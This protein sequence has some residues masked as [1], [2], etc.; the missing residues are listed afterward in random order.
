[1]ALLNGATNAGSPNRVRFGVAFGVAGSKPVLMMASAVGEVQRPRLDAHRY[2]RL[3][4]ADVGTVHAVRRADDLDVDPERLEV[5]L[6]DLGHVDEAWCV[7]LRP[8]HHGDRGLHAGFGHQLL[9]LGQVRGV[10]VEVELL[11]VELAGRDDVVGYGAGQRTAPL[12]QD[13]GAV[14]RV[15]DGLAHVHVVERRDLVVQEDV[16]DRRPGRG[17]H[18]ARPAPGCGE[19]F[20][21]SAVARLEVWKSSWPAWIS[22]TAWVDCTPIEK[23]ILATWPRTPSDWS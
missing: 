22:S 15:V 17:V 8:Q 12:L 16:G 10:R 19:I 7:V 13:L 21:M 5:G 18:L 4:V 23:T 1:M 9:G 6:D 3:V 14:D 20:R 2:P 11:V